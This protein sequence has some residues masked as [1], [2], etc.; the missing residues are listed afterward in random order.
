MHD[1]LL[2]LHAGEYPGSLDPP[3][4]DRKLSV[5]MDWGVRTI[6]DLTTPQDR[7]EPY[8]DRLAELAGLRG[9]D[10]RRVNFPI[11]DV[12]VVDDDEFDH[13]LAMIDEGLTRGAVYVHCWGGVGRTGTVIGAHLAEHGCSAREAIDRMTELRRETRK[14][15][16]SI[17]QTEEQRA[18]LRRR[19]GKTGR[20]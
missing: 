7:L 13:A 15:T 4:R 2:R 14:G 11:P 20:N 19:A 17:P 18:V 1:L 8:A 6:V 5:L 10:L 3:H 9:L 16:R 12:S